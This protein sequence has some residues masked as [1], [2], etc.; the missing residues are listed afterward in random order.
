MIYTFRSCSGKGWGTLDSWRRSLGLSHS[1][2]IR[3]TETENF[4]VQ[5][6]MGILLRTVLHDNWRWFCILLRGFFFLSIHQSLNLLTI[7]CTIHY[8]I[9]PISTLI[10]AEKWFLLILKDLIN[11]KETKS[12]FMRKGGFP[13]FERYMLMI[14]NSKLLH[15][16]EWPRLAV[17]QWYLV[18][19]WHAS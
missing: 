15:Q 9:C 11:F 17:V 6:G 2:D 18:S 1:D 4:T 12:L 8:E 13:S 19:T 10:W 7:L 5:G 3:Y 14:D 16:I